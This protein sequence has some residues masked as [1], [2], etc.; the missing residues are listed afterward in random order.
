[1]RYSKSFFRK[2]NGILLWLLPG[3]VYVQVA[4]WTIP[5]LDPLRRDFSSKVRSCG[6]GY[7]VK[8]KGYSIYFHSPYNVGRYLFKRPQNDI[9][10]RMLNKYLGSVLEIPA[11]GLVIDVGANVG[12]FSLAIVE[13]GGYVYACEPDPGPY[14]CLE[15]N[16]SGL[17]GTRCFRVALGEKKGYL[18][19][20]IS[21]QHNDSSFVKP[22]TGVEKVE[23]IEV[24]SIDQFCSREEIKDVSLLKVEAE[25]YEPEILRGSAL[26]LSTIISQVAVDGGPERNGQTTI[27]ECDWIL[28]EKGFE[29]TRAGTVLYGVKAG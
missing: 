17:V 11:G 28:K 15:K 25:G 6:C 12:E 4:R 23:E 18:P 24:C 1:M 2:V 29:T 22:D 5:F 26:A 19:F 3:Y 13:Q 27:D 7:I 8:K 14:S 9:K 16:L 10:K 21:S 20:Y